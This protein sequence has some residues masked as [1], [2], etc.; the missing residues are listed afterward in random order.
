MVEEGIIECVI[1]RDW[2]DELSCSGIYRFDGITGQYFKGDDYTTDDDE[3]WGYKTV[4]K[5][6]EEDANV[7]R[8]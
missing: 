1:E 6:T 3:E 5:L 2:I 4:V 7:Y 8:S